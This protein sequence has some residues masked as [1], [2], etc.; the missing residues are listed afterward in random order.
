MSPCEKRLDT[1]RRLQEAGR[2]Q[3]IEGNCHN[4]ALIWPGFWFVAQSCSHRIHL[5]IFPFLRIALTTA[6][7]M[8]EKAF[9]PVWLADS[10]LEQCF[11]S[12]VAQRLNPLG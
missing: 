7:Q 2:L 5:H 6:Q 3:L 12:Y 8:I 1:A 4:L 9:L 10:K 11:T